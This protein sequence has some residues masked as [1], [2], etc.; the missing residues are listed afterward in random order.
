[1]TAGLH[2]RRVALGISVLALASLTV[3]AGCGGSGDSQAKQA[4]Q[5]VERSL[6]L[7]AEAASN[8]DPTA[9]QAQ[10]TQALVELRDAQPLASI[11]A[12][13]SGEWE[14]LRTTLSESPNVDESHLVPALTQQCETAELPPSQRTS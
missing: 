10:R 4:C 14:A 9:A 13:A 6:R 7:Y 12:A 2:G 11:A 8:P 5:H 3:I 1:L